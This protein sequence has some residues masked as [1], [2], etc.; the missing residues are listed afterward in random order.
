[1]KYLTQFIRSTNSL[2]T[3]FSKKIKSFKEILNRFARRWLLDKSFLI[4]GLTF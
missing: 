1:M 2:L 4:D 3:V